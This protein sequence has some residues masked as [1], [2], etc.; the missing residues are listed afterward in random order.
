MKDFW[1]KSNS[2]FYRLVQDAIRDEEQ[3]VIEYRRLLDTTDD[4]AVQQII[5]SIIDDEIRHAETL[6]KLLKS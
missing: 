2:V 1:I 6:K 3:G 5:R 4:P